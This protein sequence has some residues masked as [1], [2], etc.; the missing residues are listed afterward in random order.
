MPP[1][2]PHA[3]SRT[4]LA[5]AVNSGSPN[6]G[7]T[8]SPSTTARRNGTARNVVLSAPARTTAHGSA[9]P[10]KEIALSA[11]RTSRP[12][13]TGIV[14]GAGIFSRRYSD[15]SCVPSHS[16][17]FVAGQTFSTRQSCMPLRNT[18]NVAFRSGWSPGGKL[19]TTYAASVTLP[20]FRAAQ[21]AS[22]FRTRGK[23]STASSTVS[24]SFSPGALTVPTT[25]R[26]SGPY[27]MDAAMGALG[28]G[29]GLSRGHGSAC[30]T[31][32]PSRRNWNRP[33]GIGE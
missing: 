1:Q 24:P 19:Q 33:N 25:T 23:P 9:L 16:G 5:S 20:R 15:A 14:H 31:D 7:T 17:T 12:S 22:G 11:N 18:R 2:L 21:S 8:A 32:S 10:P 28:F 6:A 26:S 4:R 3:D 13:I 29:A 30:G 27:S